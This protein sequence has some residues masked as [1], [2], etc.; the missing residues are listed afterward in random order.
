MK[1]NWLR[2]LVPRDWTAE[3]ALVAVEF[4]GQVRAAVWDVHGE[5]MACAIDSD[6]AHRAR[7]DRYIDLED[8]DEHEEEDEDIPF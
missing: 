6:P 2:F 1:H 8:G 4:L 3:Q 5:D 7:L